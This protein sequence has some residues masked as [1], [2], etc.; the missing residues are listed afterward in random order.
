MTREGHDGRGGHDVREEHDA[1]EGHDARELHVVFRPDRAAL[2]AIPA[3]HVRETMRPL[4]LEPLAGA[5]PFVLGAAVVRGRAVPVLDAASLVRG[6]EIRAIH[7]NRANDETLKRITRWIALEVGARTAVLAVHEVIGVQPITIVTEPA[8][9]LA[10][11]ARGAIDE[12]ASLDGELL[13]VLRAGRLV[14][15]A[16]EANREADPSV[17]RDPSPEPHAP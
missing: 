2:A 3:R 5:P 6:D 13:A 8:P 17:G 15:L 7:D 11:A 12:L 1:R 14:D 16:E 10:R 4:P 9:L